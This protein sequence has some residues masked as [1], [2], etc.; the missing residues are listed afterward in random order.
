MTRKNEPA[1]VFAAMGRAVD[2]SVDIA[3]SIRS[4]SLTRRQF[5][6]WYAKRRAEGAGFVVTMREKA[7]GL[8]E[9]VEAAIVQGEEL[10]RSVAP[11][12]AERPKRRR[13][14]RRAAVKHPAPNVAGKA[15]SNR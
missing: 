13:P 7:S 14:V 8:A 15:K 3:S 11:R 10:L 5:E 9:P 12:A 1:G 6:K 4:G 2:E